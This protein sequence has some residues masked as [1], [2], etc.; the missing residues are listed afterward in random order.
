MV[1]HWYVMRRLDDSAPS[2]HDVERTLRQRFP[3]AIQ[4]IDKAPGM[5]LIQAHPKRAA[6]LAAQLPGWQLAP[7]VRYSV[8]QAQRHH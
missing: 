1:T 2:E 3:H 8:S 7:E 5:V 4:M 6:Q